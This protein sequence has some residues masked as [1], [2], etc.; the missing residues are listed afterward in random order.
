MTYIWIFF[1]AL[2]LAVD[3]FTVALC[4]GL[5]L[6]EFRIRHALRVAVM[7]SLVQALM[8]LVGWFAGTGLRNFTGGYERWIAF[9]LLV[10]TGGKMIWESFEL[11]ESKQQKYELNPIVLVLLALATSIDALAIGVSFAMLDILILRAICVIGGV[12]FVMSCLG[13]YVGDKVGHLFENRL[14]CIAGVVLL[15]IGIKIVVFG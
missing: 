3:S 6:K 1:I 8:P 15:L 11:G 9:I 5:A 12:T 10:I 4:I 14:E 2:S 13:V 7:F